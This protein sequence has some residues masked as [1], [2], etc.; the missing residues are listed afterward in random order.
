LRGRA[1]RFQGRVEREAEA[2]GLAPLTVEHWA[3]I[4]I[5]LD[6]YMTD[7]TVPVAVRIGRAVGITARRLSELF[8][9]GAAK[10]A[11]RLAGL[12]LPSDVPATRS[13]SDVN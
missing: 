1:A 5:V 2:E 3:V 12:E 4:Q 11:C 9:A 7:G 10:T 8:P 13:P 6:A